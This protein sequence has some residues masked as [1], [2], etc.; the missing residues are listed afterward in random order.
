MFPRIFNGYDVPSFISSAGW[1]N[2]MG[3]L[4]ERSF[5][6]RLKRIIFNNDFFNYQESGKAGF[7]A[8]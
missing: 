8:F 4:F 6:M 3:Q 2:F 7:G 1:A 5:S